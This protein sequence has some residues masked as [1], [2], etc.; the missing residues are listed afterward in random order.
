MPFLS[1][2]LLFVFDVSFSF[3]ILAPV[4]SMTKTKR[5]SSS[6]DLDSPRNLRSD[7]WSQPM[8]PFRPRH[9]SGAASSAAA[10]SS[11][12][13]GLRLPGTSV[14]QGSN[15]AAHHCYSSS[16]PSVP[17]PNSNPSWQPPESYPLQSE[18]AQNHQVLHTQVFKEVLSGHGAHQVRRL[19]VT[20]IDNTGTE[21]NRQPEFFFNGIIGHIRPR[22]GGYVDSWAEATRLPVFQT[23]GGGTSILTQSMPTTRFGTNMTILIMN[24]LKMPP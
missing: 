13:Q 14:S 22:G 19:M 20:E 18:L 7:S 10:A 9:A 1:V 5:D 24:R 8:S 11:S 6:A 23:T 17:M 4:C 16:A 12:R 3:P 21:R 15:Q 2:V